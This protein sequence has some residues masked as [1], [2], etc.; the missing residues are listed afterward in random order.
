MHDESADC[1]RMPTT[2]P[3][4]PRAL[5]LSEALQM[6]VPR[7]ARWSQLYL[8]PLVGFQKRNIFSK[9]AR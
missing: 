2:I 5:P 1:A 7:P 8:T 6:A 3:A 4:R 9:I